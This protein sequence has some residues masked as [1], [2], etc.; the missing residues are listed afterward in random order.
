MRT[1]PLSTVEGMGSGVQWG[2]SGE[3]LGV[4]VPGGCGQGG[5]VCPEGV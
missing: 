5:Y 1:A 4:C 2:V 3:C